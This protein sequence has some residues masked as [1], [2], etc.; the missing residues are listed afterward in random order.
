MTFFRKACFTFAA[1]VATLGAVQ[2]ADSKPAKPSASDF[3]APTGAADLQKLIDQFKARRDKMLADHQA[4]LDQLKNATED[5]KKQ[6]LEKMQAQQKDLMEAQ[7]ALG[8]QIRDEMRKLRQ[9]TP[10]PGRR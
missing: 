4:F 5:Q 10:G 8:K 9:A 3:V 6:I 2:A 7:R 1:M